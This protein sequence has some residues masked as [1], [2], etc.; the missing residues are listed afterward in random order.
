MS[1]LDFLN[2]VLESVD[3]STGVEQIV[4]RKFE[5]SKPLQE[6]IDINMA[7][8]MSKNIITPLMRK[9]M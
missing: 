7:V 3:F 6:V 4:E 2:G 1:V 5:F 8:A 9:R